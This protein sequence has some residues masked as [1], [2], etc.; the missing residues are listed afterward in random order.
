MFYQ[1]FDHIPIHWIE[2]AE[3]Y[4]ERTIWVIERINWFLLII[5]Y[6]LILPVV[7]MSDKFNANYTLS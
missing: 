3:Q 6:V 2:R 1:Y 5:S 4:L 7:N